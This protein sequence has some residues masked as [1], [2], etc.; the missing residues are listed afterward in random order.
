MLSHLLNNVGK[1]L[2]TE[3][4]DRLAGILHTL[5]FHSTNA[6]TLRKQTVGVPPPQPPSHRFGSKYER[7]NVVATNWPN[8]M[9]FLAGFVSKD[10]IK[11][12]TA[13]SMQR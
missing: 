5:L 8:V 12:T 10:D 3:E 6:K 2:G 9:D 4:W 7:D 1:Q 13:K 11:S